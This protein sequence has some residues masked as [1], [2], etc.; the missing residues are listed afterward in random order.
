MMIMLPAFQAAVAATDLSY[1]DFYVDAVTLSICI[2]VL[3]RE[4]INLQSTNI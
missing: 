2:I 4:Q 3:C 1:V